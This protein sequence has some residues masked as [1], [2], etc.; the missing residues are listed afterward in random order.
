MVGNMEAASKA[1]APA[2][3]QP[4]APVRLRCGILTVSDTRTLANDKSG[5][6]LVQ[7]LQGAGHEVAG[8]QIVPDEVQAIG[9]QLQAWLAA[10]FDL[11]LSTGGTGI[12]G[13]DVTIPTVE[14]LLTKP[15][16]GFGELFRMLSYEEVGG[17]A[18]LSRA[19]GGLAGHTLIF[20]LPGSRGAVGTGWRLLGDQ[21]QHL[22]HEVR[23]QGQPG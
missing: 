22:A 4:T 3:Y 15:L 8:R 9:K 17:A 5:E 14:G 2:D 19:T 12:T 13:R 16:P 23:R 6:F 11:I 10:D 1:T 20:A 18:M 21:L 7:Q